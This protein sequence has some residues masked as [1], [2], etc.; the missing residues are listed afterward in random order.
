MGFES[1]KAVEQIQETVDEPVSNAVNFYTLYYLNQVKGV[2]EVRFDL[3][4]LTSTMEDGFFSYGIYAVA[5]ELSNYGPLV[6]DAPPEYQ[7]VYGDKI[8]AAELSPDSLRNVISH[9]V[10]QRGYPV[11]VETALLTGVD[12]TELNKSPTDHDSLT[13]DN[14]LEVAEERANALSEPYN[15][16]MGAEVAF[17][18]IAWS[19]PS[20]GGDSWGSIC[21]YLLN[22]GEPTPISWVDQGH[23]IEHNEE[24]WLDKSEYSRE[25]REYV[26][27]LFDRG[28][29][30][31]S[32]I[33]ETSDGPGKLG[34]LSVLNRV[35]DDARGDGIDRIYQAA[36]VDG[37]YPQL[38]N[39]R[40]LF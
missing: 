13:M 15:F 8:L 27:S 24:R 5:R 4:R 2:E 1:A 9:T 20:Y 38:R 25:E 10:D 7:E 29:Y 11:N 39:Y 30:G 36:L 26:T 32:Y 3:D 16:L 40:G 37:E 31:N 19:S 18:D 35:L 34:V 12:L 21:R 28:I 6:L 33:S 23:S 14:M 17:S 22:K